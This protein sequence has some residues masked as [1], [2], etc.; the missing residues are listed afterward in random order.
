MMTTTS[1]SERLAILRARLTSLEEARDKALTGK[2]RVSLAHAI[3]GNNQ[4]TFQPVDLAA[5]KAEINEIK[6]EI[7]RL[8]GRGRRAFSFT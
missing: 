1:R 3:V 8:E 7:A 5:N 6:W 4:V 2:M